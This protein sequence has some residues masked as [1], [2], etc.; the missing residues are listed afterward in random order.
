MTFRSKLFVNFIL[1]L[2]VSVALIAVGVTLISRQA[3]EHLNREHTVALIQQFQH[4]YDRRKEEVQHRVKGIAEEQATTLMA[5]DLSRPNADVSRIRERCARRLAIASTRFSGFRRQRWLD[6]FLG[7]VAG[8]LRLQDGLGDADAGLG[9]ARR[10]LDEAGYSQGPQLGL[11]SVSTVRVGDRNLYVVG[12][13]RL[14]QKFLS[15]LVLPGRHARAALP[16]SRSEFQ[17]AN[18]VDNIGPAPKADRLAALV[19]REQKNPSPHR[20]ELF[21]P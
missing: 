5:V 2:L 17:S 14:D 9:V 7:R 4:E 8:A 6:H 13:E 18:L 19:Q 10:V 12:G 21:G 20:R 1:A 16:E 15:S 11:I 3:F